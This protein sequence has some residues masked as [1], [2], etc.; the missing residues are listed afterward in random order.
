MEMA[1]WGEREGPD[2]G[3]GNTSRAWPLKSM[4]FEMAGTFALLPFYDCNLCWNI[5]DEDRT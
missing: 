1:F 5:W 2:R 4:E 3:R